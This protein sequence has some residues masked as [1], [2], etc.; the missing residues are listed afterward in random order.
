MRS[1]HQRGRPI[2]TSPARPAVWNA[3]HPDQADEAVG[4]RY[5]PM[6]S[7]CSAASAG[8][9]MAGYHPRVPRILKNM[10][11]GRSA[12]CGSVAFLFS[13]IEK[14]GR[15]VSGA[16]DYA[17]PPV[18]TSMTWPDGAEA[19]FLAGRTLG[20]QTR[21]VQGTPFPVWPTWR[22]RSSGR[23][24][25]VLQDLLLPAVARCRDEGWL[26]PGLGGTGFR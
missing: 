16:G 10:A 4:R 9:C 3:F 2:S 24:K 23:L 26:P 11:S 6:M 25:S 21:G 14:G 17:V 1:N 8:F 20:T 22:F 12:T 13:A 7:I 5:R 15:A 19:R 18:S